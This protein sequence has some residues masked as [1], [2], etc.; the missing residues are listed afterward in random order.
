MNRHITNPESIPGDKELRSRVKLFGDL[1]GDVLH[2]Q[3]GG[4]VLKAVE[5]LRKGFISLHRRENPRTRQRLMRLI[6]RI[7][8]ETLTHVLRAFNAYFSLVNIA[9]EAFQHRQRRRMMRSGG[10][11]WTGSFD[12]TLRWFHTQGIGPDELQSLFDRLMFIPVFTAHPTEAKRRTIMQSLRRI[13]VTAERLNDPRLGTDEVSDTVQQ[14]RAQIQ[15]LWKTDEVRTLRPA[16]R[17][18]IR[19]GLYYFRESLFHAVPATYR[20]VEG[21]ARRVY[22]VDAVGQPVMRVP[23]FLRFGS[24]IGGDRDGNPNVR[25]ETTMLA[26]DLHVEEI[27]QEYM[28]RLT[29]LSNILTYSMLLT[30]PSDELMKSL[31]R[32]ERFGHNAFD[33]KPEQFFSEPYRRKLYFMRYRIEHTLRAAHQ[34]MR[35]ETG[36]DVSA[37]YG[38]DDQFLADLY[39]IRDSLVAHRDQEIADGELKDLIRLAETFGFHLVQL[40]IRQEASR[41]SET[42]AEILGQMPGQKSY[43]SLD[44]TGRLELLASLICAPVLPA[45]NRRHL[46]ASARETLETFDLMARMRNGVSPHVFGNYVISMTHAASH[47]LEVMLLARIAGLVAADGDGWRCDIRVSPLFETIDDLARIEDVLQTLLSVPAYCT[48]LKASGNVQ[49]VML[50]YSDS[51]KDG[52]TLSSS[53]NLY[54]AQKKIVGITEHFGVGCR[55]FHGRGGTIGRG[56]GPTHE[57]ILAQPPGTVNGQIKFTEQGEVLY[58]KYSNAETAAY[59]LTMGVTGLMKASISLVRPP[60][61][62]RKDHLE[63]ME[64]LARSGEESYRALTDHTPG[65]MDYFY[66]ATPVNEI[67]LLNIGSR[68]SH[69]TRTDRSKSSVRAIPWVFGWAQSRHTLPAWYGLGS[70]LESWRAGDPARLE[71]LKT[72]YLDWPFFRSLLSNTQMALF[73]SDMDIAREYAELCNDPDTRQRVYRMARDEFVRTV[74]QVLEVSNAAHLIED[75]PVLALSLARRNPYLDP[76]N[77][78]QTVLLKRY[79]AAPGDESRPSVWRDP[80]LRSIN[81]IAAGMRNTG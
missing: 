36:G 20:L 34:Q 1:L 26:I 30:R 9:E 33:T 47:I 50:G 8:P 56:G 29:A 43:A 11:L 15:I 40:D 61:H 19:N 55:L 60:V 25:P 80:L 54:E 53:W 74:T 17:D 42:V 27:L 70:A 37:A 3:A 28:R 41:H 7:D 45:V 4:Q 62:D 63:I 16:V 38:S 67:G 48:L 2:S 5:T 68:P 64:Q 78:I 57:S 77:H 79:R 22:G 76:L 18:E 32:D 73:K 66:E 72:M 81:A 14:L 49:E 23:S 21:A 24:W 10:P 6:D 35:G 13:F 71:K 46:G 59:E 58:Y 75:N 31:A 39:L 12:E 69:R 51:A 65:F 44:E 52:G